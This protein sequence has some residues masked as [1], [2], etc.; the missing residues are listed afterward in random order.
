MKVSTKGRYALRLM[1]DL[2]TYGSSDTY[3]SLKDVAK[4]Q[5]ISA[6]YLEQIVTPLHRAGLVRSV[7]GAQGGYR[8]SRS[9]EK[10]TAGEILRSIEGSFAPIAC[11]EDDVNECENYHDCPTVGFWEGMYKVISDYVDS[12]TLQQLIDESETK[13][14]QESVAECKER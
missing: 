2:G 5:H 13:E 11:L 6:K 8:L 3:I 7:R 10:Y 9:P 4:R 12:V 14:N 1:I